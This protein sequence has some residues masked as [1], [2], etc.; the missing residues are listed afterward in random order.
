MTINSRYRVTPLAVASHQAREQRLLY[1][2]RSDRWSTVVAYVFL[3]T[4]DDGRHY[5]VDTGVRDADEINVRRAKEEH[6]IVR[7]DESLITQLKTHRITPG[8]IKGVLLTH[9]HYDHCSQV[10]L[11]PCAEVI[12]SRAEWESVMLP[13]HPALLTLAG[14]PRDVYAWLASSAW[15]RLK[16]IRDGDEVLP[17]IHAL[18]LGGH[19]PGSTAYLVSTHNG[20][21]IIAGDV[22]TTFAN[23]D[24]ATPPGLVVNLAEWFLAYD[25]L[26]LLRYPVAPSHDPSLVNRLDGLIS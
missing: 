12:V 5:L 20:P 3:L 11:F 6:W 8:D 24:N 10:S 22:I 14:Y 13:V 1:G 2:G 15:E 25:R 9:L 16:L 19:T 17:G 21:L 7:P 4:D 18:V 26:Q 23:W